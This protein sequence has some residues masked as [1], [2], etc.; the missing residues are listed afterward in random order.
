MFQFINW[1]FKALTKMF[2]NIFVFL[3]RNFKSILEREKLFAF[4]SQYRQ[5]A[6]K[7]K[8]TKNKHE[9]ISTRFILRYLYFMSQCDGE[10]SFTCYEIDKNIV[11]VLTSNWRN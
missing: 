3:E 9:A 7:I 2:L 10:K 6:L 4:L 1:H 5:R 8:R 11:Q